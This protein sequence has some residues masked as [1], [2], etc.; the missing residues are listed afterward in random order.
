M[1]T[2]FLAATC[3]MAAL[4]FSGL[5]ATPASVSPKSPYAARLLLDFTY[6][7]DSPMHLP[8]ALAVGQDG[9]VFVAD[10]V[11]D[12]IL[13]F[14]RSGSL[15]AE[16][17]QVGDENLSHPLNVH[18]DDAGQVWIVDTGRQRVLVRAPDGSLVRVLQVG[19]GPNTHAPDLTAALPLADGGRACVVDNDNQRLVFIDLQTG[20]QTAVGEPGEA[21]GQFQY[22]FM[23][24]TG[25][26]GDLFVSDVVNGRVQVFTAAGR[27]AGS[28][29]SFGIDPGRLYR[30][31]GVA[32]DRDG[33]V[34]IAEAVLGVVQVFTPLGEFLDVLRDIDGKTLRFEMPMGMAFDA[35]GNLYVVELQADR[36]RKLAVSI[37]PRIPPPERTRRP[38][39]SLAGNQAQACTVCHIEWLEPFSQGQGT[40]LAEAPASTKEEPAVSRAGMCL[41]CHNGSVADSRRRVW[42]EHGHRTDV[43]PP[44]D[45]QVPRNL[46]LVDG[47]VACRTCHTAHATG[48]PTGDIKTSVFLRVPN[49]ASELCRACHPDKTRGPELGTHPTGGM[50]WPVPQT[51]VDAGGRVGPNPRELTCQVCHTPHGAT[52]DHLLVMGAESN[53][54]CLTCHEQMRPGMFREGAAEH[55]LSPITTP[56]QAAA[57]R[58]L[59][60]RLGPEDRLICLSCHKL[61]HGKGKRF[62]LADELHDGAFCLRCHE[63]RRDLLDSPHDLRR[64]FPEEKNRLGMTPESGGPCSACHLFHRYARAPEASEL[65]PGGGKC[66]TCHQP[67]RVGQAK[68]LPPI[69]HPKARCSECHNPHHPGAGN[70][71]P[72]KPAEMCAKCH[73]DQATLAGGLHD[74]SRSPSAWPAASVEARDACLACHRPHGTV[75]TGLSR[76]AAAAGV[77]GP[78]AGCV[79]CH[80]EA[81]PDAASKIALHHPRDAAKLKSD[82]GLPLTTAPDNNREIACRTCHDPHRGSDGVKPLLRVAAGTSAQVLCTTCHPD[83]AHIGSIGHGM[84]P[85]RSAGLEPAVCGPCHVLHAQ[86]G[87]LEPRYLWPAQ[88]VPPPT[89]QPAATSTPELV[90]R[91][92]TVCHREGG[93]VAPP[94]I[95]T[96]PRVDMFNATRP[97]EPG[98]L[99]LFNARG[100]VDPQGMHSCHTCHLTHGRQAPAPVPENAQSI[101]QRELRARQWHLR[102]FGAGAVCST[103]HGTD[104]LRRFMYFHDPARRGGPITTP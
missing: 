36:V 2:R 28:I 11:N 101:T 104:A 16:I 33:N 20:M 17:R 77:S 12:R 43:Q 55:P 27:P 31:S 80:P 7:R 64:D 69:I 76:V 4:L 6:R 98:Y 61:H 3:V 51:I 18:A 9:A 48:T 92:C 47:R 23:L 67:E 40:A 19:R 75:E 58:D 78:D 54:L 26:G 56:A 21:L 25:R 44:A 91:H 57:V 60:T 10:G 85:L 34:W 95:A 35:D 24:A 102:S 1:I 62:M 73:Q 46:P 99:P 100:E 8:T 42:Q 97:G 90:D 52:H 87:S 81:A 50:P 72:S 37:D 82:P 13:Q 68:V 103:C 88:F 71:L 41:S 63:D 66:I 22:P 79:A 96:H 45:M 89:T 49:A 83:A 39:A 5:I 93:P 15:V 32:V 59:G 14:D 74:V 30:P 86:P 94:A 84:E 70:F 29:G 38:R 65:D 53:Q